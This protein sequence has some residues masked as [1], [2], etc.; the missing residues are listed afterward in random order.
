MGW[1]YWDANGGARQ[2]EEY[3]ESM[4]YR[5]DGKKTVEITLQFH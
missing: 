2:E 1:F 4:V 3:Y 5:L